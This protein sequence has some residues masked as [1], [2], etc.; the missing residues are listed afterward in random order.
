MMRNSTSI[1]RL[2]ATP[3]TRKK[4]SKLSCLS[5]WIKYQGNFAMIL[6]R[7]LVCSWYARQHVAR[8]CGFCQLPWK[9]VG[10]NWVLRIH[11]LKTRYHLLN[12]TIRHEKHDKGFIEKHYRFIFNH[13]PRERK[14]LT[15]DQVSYERRIYSWIFM[16]RTSISFVLVSLLEIIRSLELV[17]LLKI[18]RSLVLVSSL[19]IIQFFHTIWDLRR[20]PSTWT[21]YWRLIS[22][23][24]FYH[25]DTILRIPYLCNLHG[26]GNVS[27]RTPKFA[28][29]V[30]PMGSQSYRSKWLETHAN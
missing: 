21:F 4:L 7:G 3:L 27:P 28:K 9:L 18:I 12:T 22:E 13:G 8:M 29:A 10:G 11:I 19:E 2:G 30:S 17:S 14:T 23:F 5:C 1:D 20:N 15:N 16:I 26:I 25:E 6:V 24:A